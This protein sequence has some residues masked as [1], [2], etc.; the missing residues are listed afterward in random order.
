MAEDMGS[1]PHFTTC[2]LV[3]RSMR[4]AS[5]DAKL[6]QKRGEAGKFQVELRKLEER[7]EGE[8][9]WQA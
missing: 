3:F 1:K 5:V 2:P 7:K 9:M 8:A 4:Y 6:A